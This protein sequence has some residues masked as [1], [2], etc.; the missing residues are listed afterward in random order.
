M[1]TVEECSHIITL[2]PAVTKISGVVS[3]FTLSFWMSILPT[4]GHR[5]SD[6]HL[7]GRVEMKCAV[8]RQLI[9]VT[10]GSCPNLTSLKL[11]YF[12]F[13]DEEPVDLAGLLQPLLSCVSI[14]TLHVSGWHNQSG[15]SRS[16]SRITTA[17]RWR[18]FGGIWSTSTFP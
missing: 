11:W 15:I 5:V 14:R 18:P 16:L 7:W 2:I 4:I 12:I 17:K 10:G 13:S 6:T 8:I 9:A 3:L 1:L